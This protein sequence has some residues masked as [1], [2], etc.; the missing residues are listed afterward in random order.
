MA[1]LMKYE[2]RKTLMVKMVILGLT[3]LLEIVYLIGLWCKQED[4]LGI[5]VALLP[6]TAFGS[7]MVTGLASVV[8][9]HRDMNTKQG[10]ML[11]MTPNSC[12][13]IL[14]A[15]V[16]ENGLS[17]L[18]TGACFFAL[19][20]LDITLLVA[21][22]GQ[23]QELL[24]AIRSFITSIDTRLALDFPMLASFT[25]NMLLNWFSVVTACYLG[26]AISA[27]LLNGKKLNGL[28]S[29]L[30]IVLLSSLV[31]WLQRLATGTIVDFK[32]TFLV[33]AAVAFA[34]AVVMYFATAQIMEHK[35]SV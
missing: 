17:I 18:L 27:A 31:S 1:K 21:K 32:T 6:L 29:F 26:V 3:A 9:L 7:I 35:L 34:C 28:I 5:G 23:L 10:Y 24:D 14:G 19:G 8:I 13:R 11:F 16:L 2:F 4:M 20:A 15:K 30:I 25:V 12:Y 22:Q 33:D